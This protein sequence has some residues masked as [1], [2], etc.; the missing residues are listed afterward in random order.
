MG[1]THATTATIPVS[2]ECGSVPDNPE[3]EQLKY[4]KWRCIYCQNLFAHTVSA[5]EHFDECEV[6]QERTK[7]RAAADKKPESAEP[8][9]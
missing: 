4:S 3:I 7:E 6:L 5:N 9:N 2:W 8:R 1:L